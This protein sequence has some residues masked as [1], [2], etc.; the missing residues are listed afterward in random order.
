[1]KIRILYPY[2]QEVTFPPVLRPDRVAEVK[3]ALN[4]A[5][6]VQLLGARQCGKTTLARMLVGDSAHYFDLD[7]RITALPLAQ[8][9]ELHL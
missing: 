9:S 1:M 8:A 7:D 6:V 5:P 2:F 3:A 4:R